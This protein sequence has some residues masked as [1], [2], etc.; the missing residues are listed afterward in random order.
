MLVLAS[1]IPLS[2]IRLGG[3]KQNA[4]FHS[5]GIRRELTPI[6][7]IKTILKAYE[8]QYYSGLIGSIRVIQWLLLLI[9]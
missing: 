4:G 6:T 5:T 3:L 8:R 1:A 2:R 7:P 9:L